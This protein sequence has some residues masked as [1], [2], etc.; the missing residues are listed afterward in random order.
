MACQISV[1]DCWKK[2]STQ[3]FPINYIQNEKKGKPAIEEFQGFFFVITSTQ[4]PS[5]H[6]CIGL[7]AD[8]RSFPLSSNRPAT[9]FQY[10][11]PFNLNMHTWKIQ[12][13]EGCRITS[14]GA[15]GADVDAKEDGAARSGGCGGG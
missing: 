11:Q 13:E 12:R 4:S 6:I 5:F 10:I 8:P 14:A 3:Q 9:T 7:L 2:K 15:A 1:E